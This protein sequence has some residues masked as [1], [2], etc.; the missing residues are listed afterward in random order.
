MILLPKPPKSKLLVVSV[1]P[2]ALSSIMFSLFLM[3][4]TR[5]N[6][7][8]NPYIIKSLTNAYFYVGNLG[9]FKEIAQKGRKNTLVI[10]AISDGG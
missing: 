1:K 8:R 4:K 5:L 10:T 7:F 2:N 3:V 6:T 9:L